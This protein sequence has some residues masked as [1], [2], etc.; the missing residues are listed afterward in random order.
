M[1]KNSSVAKSITYNPGI[2]GS[3][4]RLDY[5]HLQLTRIPIQSMTEV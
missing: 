1:P 2:A 4:K 3:G 5:V